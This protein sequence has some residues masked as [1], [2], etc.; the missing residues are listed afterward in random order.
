M[1]AAVPDEF[2]AAQRPFLEYLKEWHASLPTFEF[3]HEIPDPSKVV[4]CSTDMTVAFAKKGNLSSP[5]VA[6]LITP[7]VALLQRLHAAGVR[8]YVFLQD[9][10]AADAPE[11]E[12]WPP[13][14][15]AGTEEAEMVSEFAELLFADL[16]MVISK[17][18]LHP[19]LETGFDVWLDARPELREFFV[20]GNCTDLCVYQLA[21]YL[22]LKHNA[23]NQLGRRVIVP[24]DCVQ[25]Y[26]LPVSSA[27]ELGIVPH[28]GNLLHLLFLYHL[29]LNGC[30]V[31]AGAR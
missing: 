29:A 18:S 28:P 13:H 11:F 23:R 9:T 20:V 31:V 22:R 2:L 26:D 21:M 4:L 25:T 6:A 5:R 14:A 16:F 15:I 8:N 10:H 12:A 30:V 1:R 27:R 19:A 24:A 7:I 17:N 3:D